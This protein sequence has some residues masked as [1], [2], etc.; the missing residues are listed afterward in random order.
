MVL[1]AN[2]IHYQLFS[3][4]VQGYKRA[5]LVNVFTWANRG[6][7]LITIGERVLLNRFNL[8]LVYYC[9][10]PGDYCDF[11]DIEQSKDLVVFIQGAGYI[12]HEAHVPVVRKTIEA[13]PN[14]RVIF[15]PISVCCTSKEEIAAYQ[16]IFLQHNDLYLLLRDRFSYEVRTISTIPHPIYLLPYLK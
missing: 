11:R 14:N 1:E 15:F 7:H 4:L 12:G 9:F 5:V 2:R 10:Y 3:R 6:D 13:F 16:N 8:S